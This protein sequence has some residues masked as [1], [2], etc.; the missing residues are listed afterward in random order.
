MKA[1]VEV[2]NFTTQ[3]EYAHVIRR[4]VL[5]ALRFLRVRGR[6][7]VSVGLVGEDRM[8]SLNRKWRGKAH[9]TDVLSFGLWKGSDDVSRGEIVICLPYAA[10]Q[11]RMR[12]ISLQEELIALAAHGAAHLAGLHHERTQGARKKAMNLERKVIVAIHNS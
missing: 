9:A 7:E 11:A 6:V 1:T 2:R 3:R 10:R 4:A 12:G 8:Q 5:T